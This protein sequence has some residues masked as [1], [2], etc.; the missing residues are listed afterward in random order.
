M[1]DSNTPPPL[2]LAPNHLYSTHLPRLP[3][4]H[5]SSVRGPCFHLS[6]QLEAS[7]F[8]GLFRITV[9]STRR[10]IRPSFLP[11]WLN[12]ILL[13]Q[14]LHSTYRLNTLYFNNHVEWADTYH[15]IESR[16]NKLTPRLTDSI[17]SLAHSQAGNKFQLNR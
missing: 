3:S 17:V 1:A 7:T 6:L 12:T 10:A 5:T 15:Q 14:C 9:M 2:S 8:E 4:V 13:N 16:I 11:N